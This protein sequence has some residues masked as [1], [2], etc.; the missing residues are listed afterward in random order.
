MEHGTYFPAILVAAR[1]PSARRTLFTLCLLLA[2]VIEVKAEPDLLHYFSDPT[3]RQIVDAIQSG[4]TMLLTEIEATMPESLYFEGDRGV[5]SIIVAM[6]W[7]NKTAYELLL[8]RDLAKYFSSLQLRRALHDAAYNKETYYLEKLLTAIP[9]RTT[10]F[11]GQVG[12][13][14]GLVLEEYDLGRMHALLGLSFEILEKNE[15]LSVAV[16]SWNWEYILLLLEAEADPFYNKYL[17][18][19]LRRKLARFPLDQPKNEVEQAVRKVRIVLHQRF[20]DSF[21]TIE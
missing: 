17:E 21:P 16:G 9:D 19:E 5:T 14:S 15:A 6:R 11:A 18:P 8:H 3:Q 7:H 4:N 10:L 12:F 1:K 20:P 2:A 13:L